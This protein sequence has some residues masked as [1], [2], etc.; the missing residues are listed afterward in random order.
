MSGKNILFFVLLL[1][2]PVSLAAHFL[3]W[4][5]LIVFVTAGLA[6][7][8][9]AAWM[10][11]ATEEIAVVVGPTLGGLLNA[12]FGNATELIIALVA[13][14]AGLVG[15]VKASITGSIVSNLLLVMGLSMFLG[16]LRHKE[17][18]FQPIVAR[19]NASSM[20]LA[21]IAMLLPTAMNYTSKG[22]NEQTLQNLS[23]A[24]AVVLIVVYALT[25]LFSMKTH[26]YLYDVGVAEAEDNEGSHEKPNMWLWTG[27]LLVCTLL[28]ALES[29]M[30]V[31]SLEV[32][33]SQLGLTAL[34]TGVILVPIVGNAAE[35]ATAV[36]VAM[37][38]KMDLSVSVAVGSSMQIALFVAPVLVIAG[39]IFGQPM[40]LDFNPFELVAVAVSV[41][42]ANSIS[43][44]GKSNWLE[45]ILLLAA[46]TVLGFAFYFHPVITSIG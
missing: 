35:H 24:V 33:T 23:L 43:S 31:D 5:D 7:L 21:V 46:Y 44:D 8:P 18:T 34:F 4:G 25:L 37:K 17:Q 41:L 6:I 45:G 9:L 42:I 11:T 22:I 38:D 30:L 13:L 3:E 19:V 15:V 12:T 16:G 36:T 20:N 40:D 28:V 1:F 39:W 14:N 27:V 2:I 29:E 32:A 26:T 10:G